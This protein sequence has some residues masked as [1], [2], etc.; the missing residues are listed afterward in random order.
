MHRLRSPAFARRRSSLARRRGAPSAADA[1]AR[2]GAASRAPLAALAGAAR[3]SSRRPTPCVHAGS[4]RLGGA[5]CRQSRD[6][7]AA[8][9]TPTFR[10][11]SSE[12]GLRSTVDLSADQLAQSYRRN[13]TYAADP[14]AL[15]EEPLRSPALASDDAAARAARVAAPHARRAARGCAAHARAGRAALR[16]G[17][18]GRP[19]RA[20]RR[21]AS[22]R[23][24][25]R[26][27]LD[28]RHRERPA[29]TRSAP[30]CSASIAAQA[31]RPSIAAP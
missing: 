1:P 25:R 14:Y 26:R 12:R 2:A 11:R 15:A 10:R 28:R 7:S 4:A 5:D 27:S 21:A 8:R 16:E 18:H 13:A 23:A 19:R 6:V 22:I 24:T 17:G 20:S 3:R 29:P 31:R 9:S 30:P